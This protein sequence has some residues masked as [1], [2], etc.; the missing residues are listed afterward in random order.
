M[1]ACDKHG[2]SD[3]DWN[4]PKMH[5]HTHAFSDIMAKGVTITYNTKPN[6]GTHSGPKATYKLISNGKEFEDLVRL[7]LKLNSQL[8]ISFA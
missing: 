5:S 3:K 1:A 6:E 4:V 2:N 8:I 7:F